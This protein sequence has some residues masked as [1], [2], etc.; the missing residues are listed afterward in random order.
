MIEAEFVYDLNDYYQHFLIFDKLILFQYLH[1]CLI[2]LLQ[3]I[4][5][6]FIQT[7]LNDNSN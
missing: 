7:S 6:C 5:Y 1:L 3:S 2:I 4:N